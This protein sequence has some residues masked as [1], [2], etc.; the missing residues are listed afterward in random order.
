MSQQK[1]GSLIVV[2]TGINALSQ[3]TMSAKLNIEHADIVFIAVTGTTGDKWLR[4][5]N[6]NVVS[7]AELYQEGKSRVQTYQDMIDAIANEVRAGKRVCAA[8]YGHPGIF[9]Y[10]TH[11]VV[12]LL[13]QEGYRASMEPGISA[14]DC[15]VADLGIDPGNTGCQAIEA[16]QFLFYKHQLDPSCLVILWQLALAGDHTLR[17]LKLDCKPGLEVLT[18][19]LLGYYPANHEVIV[20]EAA[21]MALLPPRIDRMPLSELPNSK[22]TLISTLVIPTLGM[23]EFD[24]QTLAKLGLTAEQVSEKMKIG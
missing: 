12:A 5:L 22:P 13:Q 2:G 21:T 8:Y 1:K 7:L 3:T 23:P 24:H 11:K 17:S 14:E 20:Y 16:T 10:P 6:D 4:S 15:I 9:V 18:E 19:A